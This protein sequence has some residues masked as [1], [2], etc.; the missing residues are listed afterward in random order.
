M[1]TETP[2]LWECLEK[3]SGKPVTEVMSTWTSQ[4]GFPIISLSSFETNTDGQT[5]VKLHQ[6]KFNADGSKGKADALWKIPIKV[7]PI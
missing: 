2:Q 5:V 1:N 3:A 7:G 4:M 6:T